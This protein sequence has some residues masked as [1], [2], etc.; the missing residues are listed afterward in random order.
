MA[1]RT[2]GNETTQ[3]ANTEP[4]KKEAYRVV[5]KSFKSKADANDAIREAH[6]KGYKGTGLYVKDNEF[7][8]LFGTYESAADARAN[9]E[10]VK[11]AGFDD[12]KIE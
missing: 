2:K 10:A 9:L 4:K 1:A 11:T 7:V 12:A 3:E 6:K 8:L 5:G